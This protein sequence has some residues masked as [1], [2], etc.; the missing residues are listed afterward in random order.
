MFKKYKNGAAGSCKYPLR[1]YVIFAA[2]KL[3]AG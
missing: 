1:R 2:L 3:P